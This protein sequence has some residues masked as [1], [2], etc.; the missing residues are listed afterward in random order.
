MWNA[1]ATGVASLKDYGQQFDSVS[2]C[3]SKGLGAPVGSVLV[4]SSELMKR[5]KWI[6]KS[7]GGGMRQTGSLAAAA[8]TALDEVYPKLPGTHIIAQDLEKHFVGLGLRISLPVQTNMVWVDLETAGLEGSWL[9]AEGE[10]RGVKLGGIGRIVVHHQIC[11][12]AVR[13][14]KAA[15]DATVAKA[16][17]G[18]L[19]RSTGDRSQS[20]YGKLAH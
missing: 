9:V 3:F 5:G 13:A 4:G 15:V 1:T 14:L 2:L 8:W 11:Q 12:D 20:A 19:L 16:A 18:E 17:S 10:T 6:R 7:I